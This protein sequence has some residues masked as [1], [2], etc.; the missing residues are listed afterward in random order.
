MSGDWELELQLLQFERIASSLALSANVWYLY[1]S[2]ITF[3]QEIGV[4]WERKW[5]TMTWVYVLT[6]YTSV[7]TSLNTFIPVWSLELS[8]QP[9]H[10]SRPRRD[11]I[12]VPRIVFCHTS[13]CSF[14]RQGRLVM[15]SEACTSITTMSKS[16]LFGVFEHS[17][18][19]II[20][21]VLIL[22]VTWLK[23]AKAYYEARQL[24][25]RTPIITLLFRD[26]TFCFV[27]LLIVNILQVIGNNLQSIH[28][29]QFAQPFSQTLPPI[30][31][32][33]FILNL[34]QVQPAGSSW[35]SGSQSASLRFAGNAG[36]LLQF[37]A[38]E[39]PEEE[40]NT[41]QRSSARV[42]ELNVVTS[43]ANEDMATHIADVPVESGS[44]IHIV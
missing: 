13:V 36:E 22:L 21:D 20:A 32:C 23:T 43:E 26:G 33:R 15:D 5:S 27:I 24:K 38:D 12:L 28:A 37:G 14:E 6:R 7:L 34:R 3:S 41:V 29:M 17:T 25:I 9:V 11:T 35:I 1:E 19:V 18:A 4:I 42:E 8:G 2:W 30:I 10:I 31:V 40:D 39:E 16:L 44:T